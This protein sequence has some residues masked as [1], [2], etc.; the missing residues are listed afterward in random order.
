M[1]L[2]KSNC[3]T[4]S[5]TDCKTSLENMRVHRRL[6]HLFL[7]KQTLKSKMFMIILSS[8]VV[9][10]IFA[11]TFFVINDLHIMRS[12][13]EYVSSSLT[14][15]VETNIE[16]PLYF[17][18]PDAA[19]EILSFL[20]EN[21][22]LLA[23]AVYNEKG[24][25]FASYIR[26]GEETD[27]ITRDKLQKWKLL[28]DGLTHSG[29]QLESQTTIV[30]NKKK[31]GHLLVVASK[32]KIMKLIR[33]YIIY[34]IAIILATLVVVYF[35][36]SRFI[37]I[38]ISPIASLTHAVKVI[39]K[40]KNYSLR[41]P[42]YFNSTDEIHYMIQA[43][44]HMVSEIQFRDVELENHKSILEQK[45]VE[46]TRRLQ[47]LNHELMV[48]KEKADVANRAKSA[49]LAS[50][51]HELRT[52]LNGILG[53]TQIMERNGNLKERELKQLRIISQSGEHLLM[54]INDILD[55]SKIEAG[56]MEINPVVF[57][58]SG[59]LEATSAITRIKAKKK[60]IHFCLKAAEDLPQWVI[61]DE[62]RI[63]QVLFNILDNAVKFTSTGGVEYSVQPDG[64]S[65]HSSKGRIRF[66]I[67]DTGTGIDEDALGKIFYP[68]EQAGSASESAQ[69]TGLGLAISQRLVRLMGSD[70]IVKST[71]EEGSVFSFSINL[72]ETSGRAIKLESDRHIAAIA[73]TNFNILVADDNLNNR[74]LLRDALEPLGFHVH[75]AD[76][77]KECIERALENRPDVILMDLMMPKMNGFEAVE[78]IRQNPALKGILVIAISAS[79]VNDSRERSL[80]AGCDE[81][82]TKPVSLNSLFTVMSKYK[83]IDWIYEDQ[84]SEAIGGASARYYASAD[85]SASEEEDGS[86]VFSSDQIEDLSKKIKDLAQLLRFAKQGDIA[87]IQGWADG[88]ESTSDNLILRFKKMVNA[89]AENFMVDE[90]VMLVETIMKER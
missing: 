26:K 73:N 36:S 63:R 83:E 42:C 23:A 84:K 5:D 68:F 38:L 54:M 10:L 28:P 17:N 30:F 82:L 22:D 87:G 35:I 56:K 53:Y 69:G 7:S 9:A 48:S 75:M 51:S 76:N 44:N 21:N 67:K 90:I 33:W 66:D 29:N 47:D 81:F 62:V 77:G 88:I 25:L 89:F 34:S 31:L 52:P 86:T 49:F 40:E 55:L 72:P 1:S 64:D 11:G 43:F 27:H 20:K 2:S 60:N 14:A 8:N 80:R 61:G 46:R 12:T 78:H 70:L 41:V 74:E 85:I 3:T 16:S 71:P 37:K 19:E 79:V 39:S 59:L 18:D 65:L 4:S 50:M 24:E 58:L 32:S 15:M 6:F 13:I 57:S 45:V